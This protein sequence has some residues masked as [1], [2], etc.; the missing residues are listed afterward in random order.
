MSNNPPVST[1]G[2]MNVE[3]VFDAEIALQALED[4]CNS[5]NAII[6]S[7]HDFPPSE[8]EEL[9]LTDELL[10]KP[11]QP[12]RWVSMSN[13]LIRAAHG[14]T[15]SEKRLIMLA[16]SK[17]DSMDGRISMTPKTTVTAK[18]YA[19]TYKVSMNTAYDE[20]R[21]ASDKIYHKS[22]I[23]FEMSSQRKG[24]P[25]ENTV[26]RMR[27]IGGID[28]V[29]GEATIVLHWIRDLLVH[30]V[31]LKKQFT[32]YRLQQTTGFKSVYT[33]KLY[34]L[35]QR[36]KSTGWAE[37]SIEDF[38]ESMEATEKQR[39]NFANIRRRIIEPAIK[40]LQD[41]LNWPITWETKTAGRRVKA[42][43][44]RFEPIRQ[45]ELFTPE[46]LDLATA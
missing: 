44:F 9:D 27:W 14:L 42:V 16:I 25:I 20:L 43:C 31:G 13:A 15:L 40:E 32:T 24:R 1:T 3:P 2:M 33:W 22:I 28:Y 45:K 17:L 41:K 8:D 37:Y 29:T 5:D 46:E 30:L 12:E 21:A 39:Q 7:E 18:E 34:E 26:K 10:T 38:C 6:V 36:F 19:E 4:E 35:L 11:S 23:F